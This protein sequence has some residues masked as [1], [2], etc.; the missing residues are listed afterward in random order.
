MNFMGKK[1]LSVIAFGI[2]VVLLPVLS[3]A[4][5]NKIYFFYGNGCPHCAVVE[6]Y[7]EKNGF[8]DK[9]P[10]ENKEIYFNRDNAFLYNALMGKLGVPE[11]QRGVPTLVVGDKVFVGDKPIIDNFELAVS[12]FMEQNTDFNTDNTTDG[13]SVP[14]LEENI[15]E[16]QT[17]TKLDLTLAA[18]VAAS[19]VD[20]INPCAFAVLIILMSTILATGEGKKALRSGLAFSL[21]IF[22]SY[23]L[24]G[25]GL[26]AALG[27]GQISGIFYKFIGVLALILGLFN[28]KDYFWYGKV[29]LME[30][31]VSWRPKMKNLIGSVTSPA[32][33]FGV[34]FLVSLFLLPCTSGPYIVILGMLAEKT[35]HARAVL[36]LLLYNIIFVSPMVLISAAVYKGFDPNKAEQ[37]RQKNLRVLHLVAGIILLLMGFAIVWGLI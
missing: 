20:A 18:V 32:G 6:E 2:I 1:F 15:S 9:Y 29:F 28:L 26:Y 34:G 23:F 30:V 36:Y 11:Q 25:I 37:I 19:L 35:L 12:E 22:I 3:S 17:R 10:I 24:M 5:E 31:P 13:N 27:S 4:Q 16:E 14:E 7:F 21:S 8:F 33:A